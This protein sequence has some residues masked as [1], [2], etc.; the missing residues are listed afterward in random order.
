MGAATSLVVYE[1]QPW[2]SMGLELFQALAVTDERIYVVWFYCAG[3][4]LQH[5][6]TEGTDGAPLEYEVATG[7]CSYSETPSAA[8][9]TLPAISMPLPAL[10]PGFTLSGPAVEYDG[11]SPGVVR[12]ADVEYTL[13]PFKDSVD[14]T[15]CGEPGWWELHALLWDERGARL[16]FVIVYLWADDPEHALLTYSL[17]LPELSDPAGYALLSATWTAP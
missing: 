5:L 4:T 1:H 6:W 12:L 8:A 11:T 3:A 15:D 14:C 10:E 16:C 7:A 17:T 2:P 9:V 13:L